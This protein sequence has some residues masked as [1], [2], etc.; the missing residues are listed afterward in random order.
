MGCVVC[1]WGVCGV[2]GVCWVY[3]VCK[4]REGESCGCCLGFMSDGVCGVCLGVCGVFG[5]YR[6]CKAR[7]VSV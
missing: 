7:G 4:A 6:V 3:G 1:V 5:V 2:R